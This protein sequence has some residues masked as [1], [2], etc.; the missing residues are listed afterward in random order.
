MSLTNLTLPL[1]AR[2]I[3]PCPNPDLP[4]H[5]LRAFGTGVLQHQAAVYRAAADH[6]IV[7][8]L[9]P[10]GTGKTKAGLS[11]LDY[12]R[13]RNAIYIAPTNALIEQQTAAA[14]AFVTA[15]GWSH[16][17]KA[18]SAETVKT[19][20][21]HTQTKR[22]GEKL[23]NALRE[24][25]NVFPDCRGG[26]PVLLVTNPDIFYYAT[27]F[28][29]GR[30]DRTNIAS[31]FYSGFSTLIFDEFHLYNA[32]Q[33]VSL[34]FYLA[35]SQVFGYFDHNRKVVLLTATPER[36]C[37]A[38]LDVLSQAG[39]RIQ[40]VTGEE[41]G[42]DPLPSQT[43]VTLTLQPMVAKDALITAISQEV[44]DRLRHQPH[45][46]G[47][48]ILDGKDTL[49]RV[50]D[51][52]EKKG[53]GAVCGRI[54]GNTPICDRHTAAQKQVIL[55]TSTVDVGFNFERDIAPDRQNLDWLIYS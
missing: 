10:T 23:Y 39:V 8:D 46:Q 13:D 15:A 36:A 5:L 11:V 16:L 45:Q 9:A 3:A 35:L 22:S 12:N 20:V 2:T 41:A 50:W 47:A 42:G 55:A 37:T 49:N 54:T 17:V 7:L 18:A 21:C 40:Q 31:E 43:A 25:A 6:D 1:E 51:Q 38:A 53:Y 4:P 24:P 19:W 34:L 32:K 30:L 29:Y 48:V 33:L 26:Q 27:F 28:A 44:I 14:Q 52:L